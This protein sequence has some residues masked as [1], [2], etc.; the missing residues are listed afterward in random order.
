MLRFR[1]LDFDGQT[2]SE[3]EIN[4]PVD[5]EKAILDLL[6]DTKMKLPYGCR[7]GGCGVCRVKV[8]EG[9]EK[10][11]ERGFVEEDTWARCHDTN[12]VRLAC[13]AKVL[14]GSTGLIVMCPAEEIK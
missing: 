5:G 2:K 1:Y 8:I 3:A 4:S 12:D 7:S 11:L 6:D 14:P 9:A 10:L 13:Q